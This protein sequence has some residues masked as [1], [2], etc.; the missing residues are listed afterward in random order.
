ML[1]HAC[2]NALILVAIT[3]RGCTS[4]LQ[5]LY[6]KENSAT[7]QFSCLRDVDRTIYWCTYIYTFFRPNIDNQHAFQ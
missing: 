4:G 3:T 6:F 2:T 1:K 5:V 7:Y